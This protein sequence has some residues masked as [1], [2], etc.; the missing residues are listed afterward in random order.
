[1]EAPPTSNVSA[2]AEV[3]IAKTQIAKPKKRKCIRLIPPGQII[4]Q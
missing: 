2:A 1:M 4:R 3:A